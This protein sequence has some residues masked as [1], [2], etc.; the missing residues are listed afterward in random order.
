M[1][2][3]VFINNADVKAGLQ[4]YKVKKAEKVLHAFSAL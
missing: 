4:I 1:A 3:V 2:W